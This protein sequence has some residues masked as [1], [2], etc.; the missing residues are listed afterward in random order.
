MLDSLS[1]SF[2]RQLPMPA[3]FAARGAFACLGRDREPVR[4]KVH[5]EG[6]ARPGT[7]AKDV[8]SAMRPHLPP[9]SPKGGDAPPT[10][11]LRREGA[12]LH[13]ARFRTDR[14]QTPSPGKR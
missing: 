10:T 6:L 14:A 7:S 2:F 4:L 12:D 5:S 1:V 8:P 13:R 3:S 9:C 11:C